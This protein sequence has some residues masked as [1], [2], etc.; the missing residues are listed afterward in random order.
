MNNISLIDKDLQRIDPNDCAMSILISQDG[1][2]FSIKE[3]SPPRFLAFK[4][5]AADNYLPNDVILSHQNFLY[6]IWKTH[7]QLCVD[8]LVFATQS[9]F[10]V[11]EVFNDKQMLDDLI[12]F[13][14]PSTKDFKYIRDE[15]NTINLLGLV[16]LAHYQEYNKLFSPK[17]I[18]NIAGSIVKTALHY[19]EHQNVDAVHVQVW[20][21]YIEIVVIK[22]K[23]LLL[24]NTFRV[25]SGNDIAFFVLNIYKQLMLNPK[26]CAIMWSG[27]VEKF[28]ISIVQLNK[29]IQNMYF[30][31]L[32]PEKK[33]SYRF[34]DTLPH[35]F[36]HFLNID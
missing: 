34:Q 14:F 7:P 6:E 28:D 35:Y 32:N 26:T 8:N 13:H 10:A 29:F 18:H 17:S 23:K 9:C 20:K 1:Y 36:I 11:P 16:N 31:T 4:S 27:A 2:C 19:T 22:D 5:I 21:K 25:H 24:Y 3:K 15:Y 33:Y 30:E 12:H